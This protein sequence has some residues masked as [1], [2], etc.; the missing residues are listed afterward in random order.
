MIRERSTLH[1]TPVQVAG[2]PVA[3]RRRE[4]GLRFSVDIP[5]ALLG[6]ILYL[7]SLHHHLITFEILFPPIICDDAVNP[8]LFDEFRIEEF[9]L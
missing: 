3:G 9:D 5:V 6:L 2:S 7:F 1:G 4:A 8:C